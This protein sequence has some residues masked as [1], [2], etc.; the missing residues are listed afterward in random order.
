MRLESIHVNY[1]VTNYG[2]TNFKGTVGTELVK[3]FLPKSPIARKGYADSVLR[4]KDMLARQGKKIYV[5]AV[6]EVQNLSAKPSYVQ[7]SRV[8]LESSLRDICKAIMGITGLSML[9][10]LVVKAVNMQ[11]YNHKEI[12]T[13]FTRAETLDTYT[14][15]NKENI[16]E[17]EIIPEILKIQEEKGLS[18]ALVDY[19]FEAAKEKAVS[20]KDPDDFNYEKFRQD[21]AKVMKFARENKVGYSEKDKPLPFSWKTI[22][23]LLTLKGL[24]TR[25][26]ERSHIEKVK[27]E[28]EEKEAQ[29]KAEQYIESLNLTP[30]QKRRSLECRYSYNKIRMA[31]EFAKAN[32]PWGRFKNFILRK[33]TT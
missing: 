13:G 7:G 30:E 16:L 4:L 6:Q 32:T 8:I 21:C 15:Q 11:E 3:G 10:P 22:K 29:K 9:S 19:Y 28:A 5:D 17:R 25:A 1:P 2:Q 23:E 24:D 27:K 26:K 18:K 12:L 20:F 14:Y 31:E 33:H